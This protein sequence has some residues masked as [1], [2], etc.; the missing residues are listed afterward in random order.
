[1]QS[2]TIYQ[3]TAED[4]KK[5][6]IEPIRREVIAERKAKLN[7]RVIDIDTMAKLHEVSVD[8]VYNYLKSGDIICEP[9]VPNGK[10]QFRLGDAL[11][12]DF[13]ELR[14]KLKQPK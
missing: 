4:L 10:V 13:K 6:I 2:T 8:T 14:K 11:D 9:R 3:A 7:T 5:A 1:M 12:I